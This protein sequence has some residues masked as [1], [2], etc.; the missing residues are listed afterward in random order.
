MAS[1]LSSRHEVDVREV[2]TVGFSTGRLYFTKAQAVFQIVAESSLSNIVPVD[3]VGLLP[4]TRHSGESR[5][6]ACH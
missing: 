3:S 6:F 1:H 4:N 5:C 2:K